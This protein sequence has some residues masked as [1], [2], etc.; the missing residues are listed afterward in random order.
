MVGALVRWADLEREEPRLAH[1]GR[2]RL[3]DP[4]VL[5]VV[6]IR[7]DGS[8]RLSPVEPLFWRDDL[9]LSMGLGTRKATDLHRDSRIL[10][11]SIV[12]DREGSSGEFK[13]RGRAMPEDA[14]AVQLAYADVVSAQ[15]GWSP[16]PGRFHLFRVELEDVTFIRWDPSTNDQYVARWPVGQEFVRRGTSATSLGD[17]ESHHELLERRQND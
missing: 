8:P 14:D 7:A 17:P 15:L 5:L 3:A 9:W 1:L 4:G 16:E 2:Q 11:H 13:V 10:V 6:T 12:T